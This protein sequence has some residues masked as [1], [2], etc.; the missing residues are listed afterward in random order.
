MV[1]DRKSRQTTRV[2]SDKWDPD[3]RLPTFLI[4]PTSQEPGIVNP[5]GYE[6]NARILMASKTSKEN[7]KK[8]S[9]ANDVFWASHGV[10]N[11]F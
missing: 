1:T 5:R 8:T 6:V 4:I 9:L 3:C 10:S 11:L 7:G 2:I